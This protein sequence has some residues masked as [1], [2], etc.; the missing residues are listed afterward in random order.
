MHSLNM[1]VSFCLCFT[2]Y[3]YMIHGASPL[4][5]I[6]YNPYIYIY[7]LY[8]IIISCLY[9]YTHHKYIPF[10]P[11]IHTY[12]L[13]IYIHTHT[14]HFSVRR[15]DFCC[16]LPSTLEGLGPTM[17]GGLESDL[18]DFGPGNTMYI[19]TIYDTLPNYFKNTC[20]YLH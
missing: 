11:Y 20:R 5:Y 6:Y 14:H 9:I 7:I 18:L 2:I 4:V 8:I 13:Y 17:A 10:I 19:P 12:H 16:N 3:I 15:G 1:G